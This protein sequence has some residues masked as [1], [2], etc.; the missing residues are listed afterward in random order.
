MDQVVDVSGPD[1]AA[2]GF[3]SHVGSDSVTSDLDH[4][5]STPMFVLRGVYSV[6]QSTVVS[7]DSLT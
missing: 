3:A 5:L 7:W 2:V 4:R 6:D 1:D